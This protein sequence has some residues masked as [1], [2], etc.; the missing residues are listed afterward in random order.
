MRREKT[1]LRIARSGIRATAVR[2]NRRIRVRLRR[3]W[4]TAECIRR[5]AIWRSGMKRWRKHTLLSEVEMRAALDAGNADRRRED[6]VAR[7]SGSRRGN[8]GGVRLRMVS[9]SVSRASAHV[10]LRRHDGISY[11]HRAIRRERDGKRAARIGNAMS[12][13]V[14]CNRTDLDPEALAAKVADLYF[15]SR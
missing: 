10:A 4:A 5:C 2:G 15:A 12:I 3:R 11:L 8:S 14:L 7:G 1:K 13:V 9:R 6:R